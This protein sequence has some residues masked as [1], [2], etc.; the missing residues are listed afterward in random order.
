MFV[1]FD[2]S[3]KGILLLFIKIL[4]AFT[5]INTSARLFQFITQRM[6]SCVVNCV[7]VFDFVE[8]ILYCL[9]CF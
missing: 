6:F 3:S 8:F 4:Q 5:D 9:L 1:G 2:W 7:V